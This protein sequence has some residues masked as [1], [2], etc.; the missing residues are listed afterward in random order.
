MPLN[1]YQNISIQDVSAR[2]GIVI[3]KNK[4][5]CFA[6]DE[7]TPSLSFDNK[8]GVYYCHGCGIKGNIFSLVRAVL[9][10]DNK[11]T[12]QWLQYN[13]LGGVNPLPIIITPLK[14]ATKSLITDDENNAPNPEIYEWII[15]ETSLSQKGNDYLINIRGFNK[16]TIEK[17]RIRDIPFPVTFFSS[18]KDR[19]GEEP[20]LRAGLAKIDDN[21]VIK[22]IWWD[23]VIIFPF[24]NLQGQLV[25]L[26]ARRMKNDGKSKYLNLKGIR[27]NIYNL[28]CLTE[29]TPGERLII[30]EGI[31]DTITMIEKGVKAIGF[32]GANGFDEKFIPMF[33]DYSIFLIPDKDSAGNWMAQQVTEA[34]KRNGKSIKI[35]NLPKDKKDVNE[36][37]KSNSGY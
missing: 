2:L 7:K 16:N 35:I 23:H 37:Y 27:K 13:Y 14:K 15:N 31:P 8:K 6:H 11:A 30:C 1:D 21:A 10:I 3:K 19:W 9:N 18:L 5:L 28:N 12:H 20:L 26:Q 4:A 22:S 29:M 17:L 24:T 25:Y 32:L 36:Y 34:F 33:L